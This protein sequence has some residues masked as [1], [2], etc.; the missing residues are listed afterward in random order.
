MKSFSE[1]YQHLNN[2]IKFL[3]ILLYDQS[4]VL[5]IL[6]PDDLHVQPM[7]NLSSD[8]FIGAGARVHLLMRWQSCIMP[9]AAAL[10][11]TFCVFK[12]T[13]SRWYRVE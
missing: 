3:L 4:K 7:R 1:S 12:M 9:P 11:S 13:L 8:Q 10:I 6:G 2:K 5:H